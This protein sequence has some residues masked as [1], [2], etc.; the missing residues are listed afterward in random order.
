MSVVAE[1]VVL[2]LYSV[3]EEEMSLL[4]HQRRKRL[5]RRVKWSRITKK[6][7]KVTYQMMIARH[8]V[9]RKKKMRIVFVLYYSGVFCSCIFVV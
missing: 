2:S 6:Q 1:S 7:M 8:S 9:W 5:K 3:V 4:G